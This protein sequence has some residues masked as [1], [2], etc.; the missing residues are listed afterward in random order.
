MFV[1]PTLFT[2]ILKK[3]NINYKKIKQDQQ[4]YIEIFGQENKVG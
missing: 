2:P 3:K 4:T 1:V